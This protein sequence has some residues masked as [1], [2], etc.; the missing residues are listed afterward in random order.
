MMRMETAE[1]YLRLLHRDAPA[2]GLYVELQRST[3][4]SSAGPVLMFGFQPVHGPLK[5]LRALL[6]PPY[7][8]GLRKAWVRLNQGDYRG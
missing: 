4:S 5:P 7:V 3:F 6:M 1:D 2:H 8:H